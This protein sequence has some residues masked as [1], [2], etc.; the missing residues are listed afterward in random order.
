MEK[1]VQK[2]FMAGTDDELQ[3]GDVIELD[4]V[5]EEDGVKKHT[6]LEVKFQ[7]ELVGEL[8]KEGVIETDIE[9]EDED[10]VDFDDEEEDV[11]SEKD[12]QEFRMC[13]CQDI[14][15][16]RDRLDS[17]ENKLEKLGA[18]INLIEDKFS[19]MLAA[20][21]NSIKKKTASSRKKK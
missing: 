4:F 14:E 6:H 13:V 9:E 11:V 21:V 15:E 1:K 12:F 3:F 5:G 16:I 17:I 10:L 18:R 7:P 2:Y 19:Q 20:S 8:L